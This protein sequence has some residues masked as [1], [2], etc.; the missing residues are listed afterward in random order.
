MDNYVDKNS[1]SGDGLYKKIIE[2]IRDYAIILL[3]NNGIIRNWNK[4]AEKI[5]LYRENEILGKHFS[6]FYLQEDLENNLPLKLLTEARDTGRAAQEGWRRRKDGSKFWGSITIT[7]LHDDDGKVISYCKMTRDLTEKKIFEDTLKRSE[8]RYHQMIAEVEDYAIILLDVDGI[9]KNWNAGAEKI[10]G[11]KSSE[12]I[13]KSFYL[14]YTDEDRE[15]G[16]PEK[17][18]NIAR[19]KG[20]ATHE[21]WRVRRDGTKFWGLVVIT[22][23]HDKN[24]GIIGFSKVT[25][26]LTQQKIAQEQLDAYTR[27]LEFQNS[28]LEQF[29]Y[30]ASHDL[31]E[32]LRKIQTFSELI[33]ENFNDKEFT[34]RYLDKLQISAKRMSELIKSLLEYSRISKEKDRSFLEE[35]D[36]NSVVKDVLL[37]FELLVEEKQ[38]IIDCELL[39]SVTGNRLQLGQLFANIISN[40]LKFSEV[41]PVI[42]IRSQLVSRSNIVNPPEFLIGTKYTHIT[43]EDNGI[44][45]EQKYSNQ[46]FSLFQRLHGKNEFSGTGIGLALCKK[47]VEN[48]NG[49]VNATSKIGEG[50]TFNIYLPAQ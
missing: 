11:Y 9:I 30:V 43:V 37:D 8:Q 47:I 50:S 1:E 42:K 29:A 48:H 4:G 38:A 15:K 24:R 5:K 33:K 32:P 44:G 12:I 28:E 25:R 17:L 7:A 36:L 18:L 3:D 20:K 39:P 31:Q 49:F 22:A 23:L 41:R 26:D 35:V 6:I 34:H 40:S 10:K 14:F 19:T 2:E 21:G 45:F 16:L 27:E 13:G 46:I